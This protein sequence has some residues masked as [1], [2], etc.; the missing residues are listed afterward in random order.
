MSNDAA[1]VDTKAIFRVNKR[2]GDNI[3]ETVDFGDGIPAT[4]TKF[5]PDGAV[6]CQEVVNTVY[7]I[8]P[9]EYNK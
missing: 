4:I 8:D 3:V 1:G 7:P 5:S 2:E 9:K 6:L